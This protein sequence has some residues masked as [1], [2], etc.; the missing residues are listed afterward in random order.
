MKDIFDLYLSN[1]EK[2][3]L[4]EIIRLENEDATIS[5]TT[6][7]RELYVPTTFSR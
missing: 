2:D 3:V 4:M 7:L 6:E 1:D 5:D